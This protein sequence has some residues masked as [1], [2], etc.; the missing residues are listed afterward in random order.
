MKYLIDMSMLYEVDTCTISIDGE[1]ESSIR[2]S[3]QASRLLYELILNSGKMLERD[4]LIKKVWEDHGFTGSSVSLNVAISEIRKAFKNLGRDPMLIKTLRGKGFSLKAHIEHHTV[5]PREITPPVIVTQETDEM[6]VIS[7]RTL[8]ANATM[9]PK[10]RAKFTVVLVLL[11]VAVLISAGV[12]YFLLM[13]SKLTFIEQEAHFIG[14]VDNC[15]L[16]VIDKNFLEG[17]NDY[18]TM[19][20]NEMKYHKVDC[21]GRNVDLYYSWF[22]KKDLQNYFLGV[23]HPDKAGN[24]YINCQSYRRLSGS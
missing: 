4:Y 2:L 6:T 24:D 15:S 12:Y 8:N 14:K 7:D 22:I 16:Y 19:V 18:T 10:L 3:N 1:E 21:N 23:C 20:T 9:P 13:R 11:I 5:R 17:N